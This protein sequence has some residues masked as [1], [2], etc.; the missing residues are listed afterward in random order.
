MLAWDFSCAMS[1][2]VGAVYAA[3]RK[4]AEKWCYSDDITL[5]FFLC[6]VVPRVLQQYWTG[7]SS[8]A[9]LSGASWTTLHKVFTYTILSQD[10]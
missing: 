2:N 1:R 5:G 8:W 7:F 4:I 6:N 10:C 9:M 3:K